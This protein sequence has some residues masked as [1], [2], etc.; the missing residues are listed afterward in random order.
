MKIVNAQKDDSGWTGSGFPKLSKGP[1]LI[2]DVLKELS[3]Q[4]CFT[5]IDLIG[6]DRVFIRSELD[7]LDLKY[8]YHGFITDDQVSQVYREMDIYL[9][10]SRVEG[11]PLGT[12]ESY[13]RGCT[14]VST[15]VGMMRDFSDL[16]GV[17]VSS[18]ISKQSIVE[19][20]LEAVNYHKKRG[21]KCDFVYREDALRELSP[22]YFCEAW[23][24][25]TR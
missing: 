1:D 19:T 10:C 15:P 12:F 5:S 9:C 18:R 22:K 20:C 6:P 8:V 24:N 16:E 13:L 21:G 23:Y 17:F 25:V 7:N 14:V 11:G 2:V 4:G 3:N